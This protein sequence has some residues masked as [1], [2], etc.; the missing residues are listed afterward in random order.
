MKPQLL[1]V[2][3]ASETGSRGATAVEYA[4]LVTAIAVAVAVAAFVL[5]GVTR[6]KV[7]SE[8]NCVSAAVNKT[9]AAANCS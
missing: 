2:R 5:G 7:S 4:L 1:K 9:S 6:S 3:I 8:A